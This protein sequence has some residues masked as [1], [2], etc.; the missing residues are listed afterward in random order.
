MKKN[1]ESIVVA[2]KGIGL[3]INADKTDYMV[4]SLEQNA[5]HSHNIE[6]DNSLF[7]RME[8]LKYLGALSNKSK[9]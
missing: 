5:G 8:Q 7:E 6:I 1:T 9:F 4:M 2:S 3:E